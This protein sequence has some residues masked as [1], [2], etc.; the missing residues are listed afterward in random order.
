M[1]VWGL[2]EM[3]ADTVGDEEVDEQSIGATDIGPSATGWMAE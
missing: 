1:R 2:L 3:K